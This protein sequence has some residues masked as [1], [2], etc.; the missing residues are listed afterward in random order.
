VFQIKDLPAVP[1]AFA[2]NRIFPPDGEVPIVVTQDTLIRHLDRIRAQ[3]EEDGAHGSAI[4]SVVEIA[5]LG[6]PTGD[7]RASD[8]AEHSPSPPEL[9]GLPE[10]SGRR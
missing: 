9:F 3:A 5:R 8:G 6:L 2:K 4:R 7:S 1:P 10:T